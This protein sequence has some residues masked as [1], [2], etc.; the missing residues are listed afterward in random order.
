[1]TDAICP[2]ATCR[3]EIRGEVVFRDDQHMTA[4]FAASLAPELA[5]T[6]GLQLP[7]GNGE[8]A[9]VDGQTP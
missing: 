1:M 3:A 6:L 8:Q 2:G 9:P 4:T 7:A 5:R